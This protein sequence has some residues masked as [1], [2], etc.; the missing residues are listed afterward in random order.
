MRQ[1]EGTKG[2]DEAGKNVLK[3]G[4]QRELRQIEQKENDWTTGRGLYE[5]HRTRRYWI[6]NSISHEKEMNAEAAT[7]CSLQMGAASIHSSWRN[8]SRWKQ[9]RHGSSC[10][11]SKVNSAGTWCAASA[12]SDASAPGARRAVGQGAAILG[13]SSRFQL[14]L[15]LILPSSQNDCAGEGDEGEFMSPRGR[16][17]TRGRQSAAR[18][19]VDGEG[20][21]S[22]ATWR[23]FNWRYRPLATIQNNQKQPGRGARHF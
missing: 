4:W 10:Q 20:R 15:L 18:G 21:V 22:I 3:E 2:M 23:I 1:L 8:L 7:H 16:K 17:E 6:G 14:L 19:D 13:G 9:R 11:S 5:K 12:T